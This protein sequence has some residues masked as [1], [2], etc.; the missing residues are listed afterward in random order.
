MSWEW[1]YDPTEY[2]ED[3]DLG[4]G[5]TATLTTEFVTRD[6]CHRQFPD[7]FDPET[8]K[9]TWE[10]YTWDTKYKWLVGRFSKPTHFAPMTISQARAEANRLLEENFTYPKGY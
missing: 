2:C 6:R 1:F 4:N 7:G 3:R 10:L 5:I 9:T 8:D